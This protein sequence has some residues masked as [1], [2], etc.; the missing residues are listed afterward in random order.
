MEPSS[1]RHDADFIP[2]GLTPSIL[3]DVWERGAAQTATE[4]ALTILAVACPGTAIDTLLS[5]TVGERDGYLLRTR[6]Q[7][8][9][10]EFAGLVSCPR[11]GEQLELSLAASDLRAPDDRPIAHE[12]R[13]EYGEY[14][15][16]CRLPTS[17]DLAVLNPDVEV[18]ANR[19][20]LFSRCVTQ[21]ERDRQTV[22]ASELPEPVIDAVIA[23]MAD[24]DPQ[25]DMRVGMVCAAC[26]H[27]WF[28]AFEILSFFWAEIEAWAARLRH[29]VHLLASAY[30]W[31][32]GDILALS[33]M[34][35]QGYV[36]LV[37]G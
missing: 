21:A 11:C 16:D 23:R 37:A 36:E 4:R 28:A 14:R 33:P 5:L 10:D 22:R 3:L 6:E 24:A 9:G 19:L 12:I 30:G 35:R 34:R 18:P 13:V 31:S 1:A 27:E 26:R 7:T 25:A 17:R 29:E 2:R 15:I 20:A 8:F 32:E